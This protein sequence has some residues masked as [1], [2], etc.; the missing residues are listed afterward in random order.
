MYFSHGATSLK[1]QAPNEPEGAPPTKRFK[2]ES[3][4]QETVN[5]NKSSQEAFNRPPKESGI[6]PEATHS[7]KPRTALEKL[8]NRQAKVAKQVK[9]QAKTNEDRE[10]AWLEYKLG[11]KGKSSIFEED[12]LDGMLPKVV[13]WSVNDAAMLDLLD[14]LDDPVGG[15]SPS[16]LDGDTVTEDE[17]EGTS[18]PVDEDGNTADQYSEGEEWA[19]ISKGGQEQEGGSGCSDSKVPTLVP[20]VDPSPVQ[21]MS[22]S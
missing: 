1:R 21:T 13:F 17:D 3:G 6:T 11:I 8:A 9:P 19:G 20:L 5:E 10:I 7:S 4:H 14:G 12:G 18:D 15:D 16:D 22:R 2:R